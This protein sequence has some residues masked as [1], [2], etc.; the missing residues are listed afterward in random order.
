[1]AELW[2]RFKTLDCKKI[3]LFRIEFRPCLTECEKKDMPR[4][5]VSLDCDLDWTLIQTNS[6]LIWCNGDLTGPD[7]FVGRFYTACIC[8]EIL[9]TARVVFASPPN[10]VWDSCGFGWTAA[11]WSESS[12][13]RLLCERGWLIRLCRARVTSTEVGRCRCRG[14]IRMIDR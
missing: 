13:E 6:Y 5:F 7:K 3:Q 11:K 14:N 12:D 2:F 1:M 8:Q 10:Q 4:F 9:Y